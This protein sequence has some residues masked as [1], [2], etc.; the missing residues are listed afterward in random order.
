AAHAAMV[1][2]KRIR[3]VYPNRHT[4]MEKTQFT[5]NDPYFHK[6][7]PAAGWPGQWHLFN[8]LTPGLDARV[9]GAWN[10]DITGK[11]VVIGIVHDSLKTTHPDL[12][13]NYLAI[14]SWN[15]GRNSPDPN[16]FYSSDRH[17]TAVAG[18]AA[19]RGGNGIGGTGAAP[20]AN[21]AGL[22]CDFSKWFQTDAMF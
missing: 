11:G 10:R 18:V 13:P 12:A 19:A 1:Q 8:E 9:M 6:D 22:R 14:D 4:T 17:G 7:T 2:D 15:F 3:A 21:L 20:L 16:G 5:P